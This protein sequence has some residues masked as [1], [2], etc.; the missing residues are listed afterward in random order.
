L[1]FA[2][3]LDEHGESAR[4]EFIRVQCELETSKL[5]KTRRKELRLRERALLDAHRHEW[6]EATELPIEDV[7][8]DRGVIARARLSTWDGGK[9]LDSAR[10]TG[11]AAVRVMDLSSGP[12]VLS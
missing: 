3:W 1:V 4:A 9:I 7:A 6:I 11:L 10:T 2:D 12:P 5:A 8:F